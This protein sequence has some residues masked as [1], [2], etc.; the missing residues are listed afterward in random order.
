MKIKKKRDKPL[1]K[2]KIKSL[3]SVGGFILVGIVT[4]GIIAALIS[5][6]AALGSSGG[7]GGS[8]GTSGSVSK[9]N[10]E[11]A[12]IVSHRLFNEVY[13]DEAYTVSSDSA[14]K[15]MPNVKIDEKMKY[16]TLDTSNGYLEYSFS[17]EDGEITSDSEFGI[18]LSGFSTHENEV[19]IGMS[20]MDYLVIDFDVWSN[21]DYFPMMYFSFDTENRDWWDDNKLCVWQCPVEEYGTVLTRSQFVAMYDMWDPPTKDDYGIPKSS[22]VAIQNQNEPLHITILVK[23]FQDEYELVRDYLDGDHFTYFVNLFMQIEDCVKFKIGF[24]ESTLNEDYSVCF[25]NFQFCAYGVGDGSYDGDI[26]RML[27]NVEGAVDNDCLDIKNCRD[28]VLYGKYE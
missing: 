10:I 28:W 12:P 11:N 24:K 21:G 22:Y 25:D 20:A 15:S 3:F 2:R 19:S 8:S 23:V 27:N 18:Y 13:F 5:P 26:S 16:G 17:A 9:P 1:K 6:A 7:G 4:L 14:N